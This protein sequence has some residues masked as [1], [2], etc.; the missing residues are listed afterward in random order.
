MWRRRSAYCD[1]RGWTER[2]HA[3]AWA[4]PK[5]RARSALVT[6]ASLKSMLLKRQSWSQTTT[7]S[8]G[9]L[10]SLRHSVRA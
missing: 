8:A 6:L 5:S 4:P 9:V 10:D 7:R 3:H 1:S 2:G